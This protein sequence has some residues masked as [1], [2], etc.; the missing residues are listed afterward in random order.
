MN[1][2]VFVWFVLVDALSSTTLCN[3]VKVP[4]SESSHNETCNV[5]S[6]Y[7]IMETQSLFQKSENLSIYYPMIY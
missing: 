4:C 6:N 3:Y 2:L 1:Y 5:L 7:L